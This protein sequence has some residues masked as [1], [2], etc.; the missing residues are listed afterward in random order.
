MNRCTCTNKQPANITCPI[1]GM[2]H[3]NYNMAFKGL[4]FMLP[5][6]DG[7]K[8]FGTTND[9]FSERR[10]TEGQKNYENEILNKKK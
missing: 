2:F 4:P 1:H 7:A 8:L 6:P 9:L 5:I 3:Q 10:K